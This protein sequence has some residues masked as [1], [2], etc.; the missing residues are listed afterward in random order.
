[1]NGRNPATTGWLGLLFILCCG[2]MRNLFFLSVPPTTGVWVM[3]KVA[4]VL[5]ACF[6]ICI[7]VNAFAADTYAGISLDAVRSRYN[8]VNNSSSGFTVLLSARQNEHYGYELQGGLFGKVGP[9]SSNGEIDLSVIGFLPLDDSGFNLY[10]KAGVNDFVSSSSLSHGN[11]NNVGLTY[12]AG[13][14]YQ[15]GKGAARLGI[16]HFNVGNNTLSP[17]LSTNLIGITFLFK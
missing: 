2:T 3:K 15:R 17:S 16:Q 11:I 6:G 4:L 13:V 7:T 5:L 12:G 1:M 14:E 8:G 10:G 9:F